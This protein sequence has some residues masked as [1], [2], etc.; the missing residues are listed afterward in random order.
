[1][2]E[3]T[4]DKIKRLLINNIR[5][6]LLSKEVPEEITDRIDLES[7]VG[8]SESTEK[9]WEKA[10][11]RREK[12]EI[13]SELFRETMREL[14]KKYPSLQ[15][16]FP[17][18]EVEKF[19]VLSQ[20]DDYRRYIDMLWSFYS[21]AES[22]DR[23]ALEFL[24]E[25]GFK[26]MKDFEEFILRH[27]E[28][29]EKM[30]K[31][32]EGEE[33]SKRKEESKKTLK[34]YENVNE[35]ISKLRSHLIKR[36][37]V[38][39]EIVDRIEFEKHLK[40][41]MTLP[42][43]REALLEAYPE[44]KP[45]ILKEKPKAEIETVEEDTDKKKRL[46]LE[47]FNEAT[48]GNKDAKEQI[49]EIFKRALKGE[50]SVIELIRETFDTDVKGFARQLLASGIISESEYE[51]FLGEGEKITDKSRE[52]LKYTYLVKEI[53]KELDSM[54]RDLKKVDLDY[55]AKHG[56][57]MVEA[58]IAKYH[59]DI[60]TK[61]KELKEFEDKLPEKAREIENI[62]KMV[63]SE[64]AKYQKL[65]EQFK[66]V[67]LSSIM[68]KIT[69]QISDIVR[70]TVMDVLSKMGLSTEIPLETAIEIAQAACIC[71]YCGRQE[72]YA[73]Y[74]NKV[75]CREC[76]L[77]LEKEWK[78]MKLPPQWNPDNVAVCTEC[79]RRTDTYRCSGGMTY[80]LDCAAKL[81]G[82]I[83]FDDEVEPYASIAR[84]TTRRIF[85]K[86]GL[87]RF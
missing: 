76:A 9:R 54:K 3:R 58:L 15:K 29:Y 37:R 52:L 81:E 49:L 21:I 16:Y 33:D 84:T 6:A 73:L 55:I 67:D 31:E 47:L 7:E 61:L 65:L 83:I 62:A 86:Y 26:D 57:K 48:A 44:I 8:V 17:E 13:L 24:K 14:V 11:S 36:Y 41:G 42:E 79:G 20:L 1:M 51:R 53:G 78:D 59:H 5:F 45:Y 27:E 80:C 34:R 23:E 64:F 66:P 74:E 30:L 72:V 63:D 12:G 10:K 68:E 43:A 18:Y 50:K 87:R 71:Y 85:E 56:I 39:K 77:E 32:L 75:V 38:P 60:Y 46:L 2:V 70:N 19:N 35:L 28:K 69:A 4:A 40:S 82:K 25:S 22:G